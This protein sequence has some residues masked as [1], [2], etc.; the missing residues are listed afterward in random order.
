MLSLSAFAGTTTPYFY[1]G[2]N[3]DGSPQT[4]PVVATAW[5]PKASGFS[6]VGTNI[7]Y[8]GLS[9]TNQPTPTG[10]YTGALAAG[11]YQ[12][13]IPA[14]NLSFYAAIPNV[15]LT[16]NLSLYVTNV[17]INSVPATGF[18]VITNMQG[19]QSLP[20]TFTNN[21]TTNVFV[22]SVSGITNASGYVTNL[23]VAFGTNIFVTP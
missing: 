11:T 23:N 8:A 2:Q 18:S 6:I 7:V 17:P 15:T 9:I 1:S 16:N 13:T 22:S 5:P 10:V 21:L 4:N 14:Y 20:T 19:Y 12:F 3:A